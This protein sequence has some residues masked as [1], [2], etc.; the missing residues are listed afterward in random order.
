M[1]CPSATSLAA[2]ANGTAPSLAEP[3]PPPV[4]GARI[5]LVAHGQVARIERRHLEHD[6]DLEQL[7]SAKQRRRNALAAF[8]ASQPTRQIAARHAQPVYRDEHVAGVEPGALGRAALEHARELEPVLALANRCTER[9]QLAVCGARRATPILGT[10]RGTHLERNAEFREQL[11]ERWILRPAHG[12][13]EERIEL[14][15]AQL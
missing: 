13:R 11:L 9:Q 15:P 2:S 4:D 5:G 7:V 3:R 12:A 10:R 1:R 8:E 6:A 14:E